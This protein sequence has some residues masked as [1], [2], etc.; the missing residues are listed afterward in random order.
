MVM[1]HNGSATESATQGDNEPSKGYTIAGC[2]ILAVLTTLVI[3][4]LTW[5]GICL[6]GGDDDD[7]FQAQPAPTKRQAQPTPTRNVRAEN[8]DYCREL[9]SHI[10][11]INPLLPGIAQQF[12]SVSDNP[13]LMLDEDWVLTTGVYLGALDFAADELLAMEHPREVRNLHSKIRVSARLMKQFV[14]HA[15][16]G[17]DN[18]DADELVLA[19]NAMSQMNE[20]LDSAAPLM[21]QVCTR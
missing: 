6:W 21:A 9:M 5:G 13:L 17:F 10:G 8:L 4:G 11:E 16:N 19:N 2:A 14:D 12:F 20:H 7:E 18:F 1:E 3:G 15:T